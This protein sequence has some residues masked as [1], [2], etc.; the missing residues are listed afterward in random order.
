MSRTPSR[1]VLWTLVATVAVVGGTIAASAIIEARER[2]ESENPSNPSQ[3]VEI[4]RD[5]SLASL[6][7]SDND[8]LLDWEEA[9]RG[10][11]PENPDT[12]GDGTQDG[13]EV[14]SG[15]DPK[16]AGPDDSIETVAAT[17]D[18][19]LSAEYAASRNKGTLTDQFAQSFAEQYVSLKA[20]GGFT[21]EDQQNLLGTL[22]GIAEGGGGALSSRYRADL[23]PAL[24]D[25][26][27]ESLARYA[28]AIASAHIDEIVPIAEKMQRGGGAA[29]FGE[30]FRALGR[31][32]AAIQAPVEIADAQARLAN[33]Y[34]TMGSAVLSMSSENDPLASLISIPSLQKAET[35]RAEA[36]RE[37]AHYLTRRGLS[38]QTGERANFWSKM[39]ES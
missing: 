11:D 33:A 31:A 4:K 34:D 26:S 20:D 36:A 29:D 32:I 13:A 23:I 17:L 3:P 8:A 35:A 7:D 24:A 5:P 38:L 1:R 25:T 15:R 2:R 22:S 37:I 39:A 19:K 21:R 16:V 18:A 9:L 28:D 14:A 27:A 30:G 10:T 6:E 12:D